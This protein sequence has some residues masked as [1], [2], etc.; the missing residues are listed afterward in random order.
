MQ[1]TTEKTVDFVERTRCL[2]SARLG[3]VARALREALPADLL[4]PGKMLRT[5]L[6]ARLAGSSSSP[7]SASTLENLCAA[8]EIVHTASLC[9]DDIVDNAQVRRSRPSIWKAVGVS[10]AL[11][12]GDLLFCEAID[13]VTGTEEGAYLPAFLAK[14]AEVVR[15]EAQQELVYRN[16]DLDEATCLRLARGK[17]GPLFAFAASLCGGRDEGLCAALEQAGYDVGTAYQTADDMLDVFGDEHEAGKTLGTDRLRGKATLAQKG[18]G[19]RRSSREHVRRLCASAL[20]NLSPYPMAREALRE[21]LRCDFQ[22]VLLQLD[23]NLDLE[24]VL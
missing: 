13:L 1:V 7:L 15:T 17:T 19:G 20:E 18:G 2:V 23:G 16:Q 22:P 24:E 21:Y 11:L 6:A 9:H 4:A 3:A 12:V 10:G 8:V 14:A 5:R